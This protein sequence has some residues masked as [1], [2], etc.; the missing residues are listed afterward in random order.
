MRNYE[1]NI[2]NGKAAEHLVLAK[3]LYAGIECFVPCKEDGRVDIL[4]GKGRFRC[5]VKLI[6]SDKR[7]GGLTIRKCGGHKGARYRYSAQDV[8]FMI[9]ADLEC[10]DIYVVPMS[11]LVEYK[12][13]ISMKALK[14]GGFKNNFSPLRDNVIALAA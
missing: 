5:Q 10:M 4:A 7:Q 3:L 14:C 13:M 12:A 6:Y 9:G 8:D 2:T 11:A 1:S